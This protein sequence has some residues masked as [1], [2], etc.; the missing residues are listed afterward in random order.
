MVNYILSSMKSAG[1]EV[2]GQT[3]KYN[4]IYFI[5][6]L[7]VFFNILDTYSNICLCICKIHFI[8]LIFYICIK[9]LY[10]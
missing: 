5:F 6:I 2:L 1:M 4:C 9:Y 7:C 10:E 8:N 3:K